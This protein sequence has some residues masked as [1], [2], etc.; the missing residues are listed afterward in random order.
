M[1][2]EWTGS[3]DTPCDLLSHTVFELVYTRLY[4]MFLPACCACVLTW[5]RSQE[6][7][8]DDQV[9]RENRAG[10]LDGRAM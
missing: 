9:Q 1:T 2:L 7:A 10:W 6:K 3:G 5:P 8:I 4:G